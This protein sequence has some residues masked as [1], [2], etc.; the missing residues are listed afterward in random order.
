MA[1]TLFI[2]LAKAFGSPI[3]IPSGMEENERT[4]RDLSMHR[5]PLFNVTTSDPIVDII[6]NFL[7]QVYDTACP[8][9][10]QQRNGIHPSAKTK[11]VRSI[12]MG[13]DTS[14]KRYVVQT[15]SCLA[16]SAD[17]PRKW[18]FSGVDQSFL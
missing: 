7:F 4:S 18:S 9:A 3:S 1:Y 10:F 5:F 12:H 13:T 17:D 14:I 16:I 15:V 8:E 6:L 2:R 11:M